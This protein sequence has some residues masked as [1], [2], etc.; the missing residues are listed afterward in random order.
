[1]DVQQLTDL[2]E[3]Q[4]LK[5]RYFRFMDL[6][7]LDD[8]RDVFTDDFELF[9]EDSNVPVA[10]EPSIVGR[11][12]LI[13]YLSSYDPP[14]VTIHQGHMPEIDFVDADHAT[15]EFVARYRIG[16]GSA[17]R[18]HEISRR[19]PAPLV[20]ADELFHLGDES[21]VGAFAG[22]PFGDDARGA[23]RV[24]AVVGLVIRPHR[25]RVELGPT[26]EMPLDVVRQ[27]GDTNRLGGVRV[28]SDREIP[29]AHEVARVPVGLDPR[30][31][32]TLQ[33]AHS[34]VTGRDW[35]R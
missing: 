27:R 3:I 14:R 10:T 23:L 19:R 18:L 21:V 4:R 22:E 31:G 29:R 30:L 11:D 33:D 2:Y 34:V 16:G 24:R 32:A 5:A 7:M 28:E 8:F 9:V 15:V 12:A 6:K 1:M 26:G 13:R 20:Q 25:P 35:R 17:F